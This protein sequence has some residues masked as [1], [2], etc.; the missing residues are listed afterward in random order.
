MN[1]REKIQT[2]LV[3]CGAISELY[4]A[5]ACKELERQGLLQICAIVDP[6]RPRIAVLQT[7]FP[8]A[9]AADTLQEA[10][11]RK[12]ALALVASPVA[13][14]AE[15]SIACSR[16]G[17][18]VLCEKPM[19]A[20]ADQA[21]AMID[22]ARAAERPLAV[23]LMRRF[24]PATQT[25]K[26]MI[27]ESTLGKV[28]SFCIAEGVNFNWPAQSASFFKRATA[29]GG[30]LIDI[31]AHAL[32]LMLWW[33]GQPTNVQYEDDAMGGLEANCR[34]SIQY[35]DFCGEVRLS[36]DWPLSNI[37][38]IDF[39]RGW[40]EW[41]VGESEHIQMGFHH[42]P[43]FIIK[44][45]L[46][47]IEK[48]GI[49]RRASNTQR[50]FVAQILNV[51]AAMSDGD[52]LLASGESAKAGMVLIE[53]CYRTRSLMKMPWLSSAEFERAELLSSQLTKC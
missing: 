40:V 21:Q 52:P 33:F 6:N 26:G 28:K 45:T 22:A 43:K 39:E 4:Y 19:A 50:S 15:Q 16:A 53:N 8:Q 14:H 7:H 3:G 32:D 9:L 17:L 37:Y 51:I 36:R 29:G 24:F 31:G 2:V 11:K 23:G 46:Y 1:S 38:R 30:V 25:I 49:G 47:E 48:T 10:L 5:P 27:S 20:D 42:G 13:F 44:G 35:S 12:P 41:R 18:A 34:I